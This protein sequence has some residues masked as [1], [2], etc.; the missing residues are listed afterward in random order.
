MQNASHPRAIRSAMA[1]AAL[2]LDRQI[3]ARLKHAMLA[4]LGAWLAYFTLISL[5][6]RSLNKVTVPFIDVPLA[7][8]LV[9][10]GTAVIFLAALILLRAFARTQR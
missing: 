3:G 4:L 1:S 5:T 10:Q 7:S 6:A 2:R 8:F 9:A